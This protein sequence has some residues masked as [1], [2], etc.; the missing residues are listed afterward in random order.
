MPWGACWREPFSIDGCRRVDFGR[1][2]NGMTEQSLRRGRPV[3]RTEVVALLENYKPPEVELDF[4][5][6][7]R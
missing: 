3:H 7:R 4:D 5:A 1:Y 6:R 2:D